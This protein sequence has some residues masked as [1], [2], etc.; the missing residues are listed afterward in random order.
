VNYIDKNSDNGE[1]TEVCIAEWVDSPKDKPLS[2]SFLQPSPGKKD[3]VKFMFD[4]SKCDKI[5]HVLLQNGVIHL[6]EGHVI[7]QAGEVIKGKY[8]KWHGTFSH[9]TNNCIYFCRQVQSA[10]NDGRLALGEGQ[11]M[12]LDGDPFPAN[13]NLIN[14][15][16]KKILVCTNQADST[17]GQNVIVLDEP[18]ARMLK[19]QNAELGVWTVN[20]E[21]KRHSM[22]KPTSDLLLEKYAR[23]SQRRSVFLR[24]ESHKRGRPP[25]LTSPH[26][27]EERQ[28]ID[29]WHSE[30]Y[31][32]DPP[33]MFRGRRDYAW[34]RQ[35]LGRD[36]DI[37]FHARV[38]G[39]SRPRGHG[40]WRKE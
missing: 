39:E 19:P 18:R 30:Q 11:R 35:W 8:C 34:R 5:F 12:R 38:N 28:E 23:Q 36:H 4:V 31:F 32:C 10:L 3:K 15:E 22:V 24:L 9:N 6:S 2:C 17:R 16:E 13:V 26:D 37:N 20:K 33:Q 29:R 14:F 7:P 40:V 25:T 1:E 21:R 27:L